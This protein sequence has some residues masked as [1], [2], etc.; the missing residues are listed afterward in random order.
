[1]EHWTPVWNEKCGLLW[2]GT[3][4]T[5]L[6]GGVECNTILYGGK[7][8]RLGGSPTGW[9]IAWALLVIWKGKVSC[10]EWNARF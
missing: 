9:N 3:W 5:G 1:M 6:C 7:V 10:V 2:N 4:N 8:C